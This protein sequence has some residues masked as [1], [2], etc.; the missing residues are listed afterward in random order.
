VG[1]DEGSLDVNRQ[2]SAESK[3]SKWGTLHHEADTVGG[4]VSDAGAGEF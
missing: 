3:P 2:L 4:V 1:K